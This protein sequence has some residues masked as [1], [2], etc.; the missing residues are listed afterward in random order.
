[1]CILLPL[2]LGPGEILDIDAEYISFNSYDVHF[3]CRQEGWRLEHQDPRDPSS[4]II[5]KGIVFNEMK[6]FFVCSQEKVIAFQLTS[7]S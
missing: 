6:G 7:T 1:M 2:V 4:E 5:F 3:V